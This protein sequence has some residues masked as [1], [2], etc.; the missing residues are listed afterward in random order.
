MKELSNTA[1]IV[2]VD[3]S[4]EIGI[5]PNTSQLSLHLQAITN[6]VKDAGLKVKDVDGIFT[7]GQHSPSLLGEALGVNPRYVDGTTVGGC[8]FIM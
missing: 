1:C 4:D 8:S 7:A 6:A 5:L 2:G 3:E